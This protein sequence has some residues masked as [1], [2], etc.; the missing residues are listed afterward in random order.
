MWKPREQKRRD[1][2]ERALAEMVPAATRLSEKWRLFSDTLKFRD[3]VPLAEQIRS[4]SFPAS[5]FVKS[6]YPNISSA[7]PVVY[8]SAL[9]IGIYLARTTPI[10]DL[11]AAAEEIE[12]E[13][14]LNGLAEML[15]K[16]VASTPNR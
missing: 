5:G 16:F 13:T 6:A 8:F 10:P 2:F 12:N 15:R 7:D 11:L 1:R 3:G 14:G 4:F 9:L